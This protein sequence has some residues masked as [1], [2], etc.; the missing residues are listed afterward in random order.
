MAVYGKKT[1]L[2][3][4]LLARKYSESH[5]LI[6]NDLQATSLANLTVDGK[7]ASTR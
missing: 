5:T 3:L 4:L 1:H 7:K 6:N 2:V